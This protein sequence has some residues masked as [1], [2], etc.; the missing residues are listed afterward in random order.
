MAKS[1]T[2][3]YTNDYFVQIYS[4]VIFYLHNI[5]NDQNAFNEEIRHNKGSLF[6]FV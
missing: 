1:L 6:T 2:F 3:L 4:H 5:T